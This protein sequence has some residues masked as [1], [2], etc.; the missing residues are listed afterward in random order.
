MDSPVS[1]YRDRLRRFILRRVKDPAETDDILQEVLIRMHKGIGAVRDEDRI[2]AWA[3]QIT[4]NAII[5][6]HRS[7]AGRPESVDIDEAL[8]VP[9]E[10]DSEAAHKEAAE[11]MLPMIEMLPELY[12][13]AVRMSEIDGI[14]QREVAELLGISLSG[15][16]SRVQR[17][18]EKL[19]EMFLE[20]C[21]IERGICGTVTAMT[22]RKPG[23]TPCSD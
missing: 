4:R 18:R 5:D 9:E 2:E 3:Y 22:P 16:K 14:T 20:C 19:R 15:A 21:S 6:R 10:L 13:D 12:R 23:P 1:A 17:G 11:C 8:D 7:L